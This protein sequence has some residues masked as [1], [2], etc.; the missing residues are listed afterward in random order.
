MKVFIAGICGTFMAGIAQIA[1]SMRHQVIGCDANVYP[2]MSDLLAAAGITVK[3]GYLA[4]HI[5]TDCDCIVVGNALSRGNPLV[6]HVL[7]HKL[8]YLSG[9]AWLAQH[10]L[11]NYQVIA[12]AG[13]HGKTSTSSM[14]AWILEH[15]SMS[16]GFLIGGKPG[17]FSE[18]ARIGQG[19]YFIIEADEYDTAFFDKRSKFVHY[20]PD[21][22]VLNNLEF[23]HADIFDDID[24]IKRQFHHLIRIVPSN[25]C[26]VFNSD[27][28]NIG[29]VMEMGCWSN[30]TTFSSDSEEA[31][32]S[33][34]TQAA[35]FSCFTVYHNGSEIGH[36]SWECIGRHN[37][38]NALAAIAAA[39]EAGLAP[40]QACTA[41]NTY[42]P[43]DRRLQCIFESDSVLLYED[44]AHHPTAI[45][46]TLDALRKAHQNAYLI[47]IIEP[48][49]NTMRL[50]CH[51]DLLAEAL[52]SA[53]E[54]VF[55]LPNDLSWK[56]ADLPTKIPIEICHSPEE[57]SEIVGQKLKG[58]SVL[59]AMSNGSFDDI[60]QKLCEYLETR[61]G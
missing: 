17:N 8:P 3:S 15:N 57:I 43:N 22:A 56:P 54:V 45:S 34:R 7:D 23:D 48:R 38:A 41:L 44:F 4:E 5:D 28:K 33:T 60:P 59:V 46:L 51:G 30:S 61:M 42:I 53:N 31:D 1:K 18:S 32:W 50:G 47:A 13:T 25:G 14:L 27:D 10:V 52:E 11:K 16:P 26:I 40:D 35:D 24:Q 2:P 29:E 39:S 58:E 49:S 19:K 37:M 6:E 20:S 12:V 55:Y 9:P 21:I 36:V